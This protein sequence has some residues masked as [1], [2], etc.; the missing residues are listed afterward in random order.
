MET[1]VLV[2]LN[3]Y[4]F[5]FRKTDGLHNEHVSYGEVIIPT[6]V[7]LINHR[8]CRTKCKVSP[9]GAMKSYRE[10]T[11]IP[12]IINLGKVSGQLQAPPLN[13]WEKY[14]IY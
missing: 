13:P 3:F 11:G 1:L 7:V 9:V 8:N 2:R 14:S 4:G 12:L 6:S 10:R 5:L